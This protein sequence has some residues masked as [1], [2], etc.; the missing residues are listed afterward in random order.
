M[1][2]YRHTN[3]L[4]MVSYANTNFVGCVDYC[5]SISRYIS[6]MVSEVV[7]GRS[8]KQTLI[9]TSTMKVEF[10]SCFETTLQGVW[11]KSFIF[12]LMV[13]DYISRPLKI[14][15]DNSAAVFLDKNNKSGS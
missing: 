8:V 5:K 14:F 13:I 1:L 9:V 11:L 15:C 6:I 10:V 4:D 2:I 12:G 7:S 3:N